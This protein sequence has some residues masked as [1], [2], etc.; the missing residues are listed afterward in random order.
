MQEIVE[1][2]TYRDFLF[3]YLG[4]SED[5]AVVLSD[6]R[7]KSLEEVIS[8]LNSEKLKGHKGIIFTSPPELAFC[9]GADLKAI[10]NVT[11]PKEGKRL[12]EQG[13]RIFDKIEALP[14]PTFAAIQGH[15]VGGG[16]ELA[17]SCDYRLIAKDEK[18]RIGL[19]ET[20]LGILPGFGGTQRLPKLLGLPKAIEF[21]TN[22]KVV[23]ANQAIKLGLVDGYIELEDK[24]INPDKIIQACENLLNN[25]PSRKLSFVNQMLCNN[26]I[27][28]SIVESK[29][30]KAAFKKTKGNYP[31][32]PLSIDSCLNSFKLARTAAYD[33]EAEFLGKLIASDESKSLVHLFYLTEFASKIGKKSGAN[34]EINS[35]GLIGAGVMGKGIAA[36]SAKS[37]IEVKISDTNTES[38]DKAK[39]FVRNFLDNSRSLKEV[40]KEKIFSQLLVTTNPKDLSNSD[41]ILEAAVENLE[42]KKKIFANFTESENSNQTIATNTSSLTLESIFKD[43]PNKDRC[44]GVHFFNPVEKM[45]LVEIIRSK[46]TSDLTV[47][48]ACMFAS[49]LGKYPV[50]VEDVPGFLV[51]RILAPYLAEASLLLKEGASFIE[52]ENVITDFGFPMGPFRLLDEVGLDIAGKVQEVLTKGYGKRMTGSGY[53]DEVLK[54]GLLGRKNGNGFYLHQNEKPLI[55]TN[56]LQELGITIEPAQSNVSKEEILE[57]I[58]TTIVL[59]AL[60]AYEEEVAGKP[61]DEAMGQIDLASVMGFGFPPFRGGVLFYAKKIG[62]AKIK[63]WSKKHATKGARFT[64]PKI[65]GKLAS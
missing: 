21:I 57:R 6:S 63:D 13:Q 36:V 49:K 27:G 32:I 47:L 43:L 31:A 28:R 7:M 45:P 61:S 29:S 25:P 64:A 33:K 18:S 59:E 34:M 54:K 53:L 24:K 4:S 38:L 9:V 37:K 8:S 50:V 39:E 65:L 5:K 46:E 14:L 11:D 48:K 35:L 44:I 17:L 26:P 19:P 20:K 42:V 40:E 10:K 52:L 60:R 22:A 62:F 23:P 16:C 55:N 30:K 1:T 15:C 41:L 12:A 2:K 3:I 56:L 51:N 58:I